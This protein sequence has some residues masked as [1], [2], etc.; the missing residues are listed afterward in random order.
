MTAI[1]TPIAGGRDSAPHTPQTPPLV[2][3]RVAKHGGTRK[4]PKANYDFPGMLDRRSWAKTEVHKH[5]AYYAC[6][7]CGEPATEMLW[8][9]RYTRCPSGTMM[10]AGAGTC[11][12]V[13]VACKERLSSRYL[14]TRKL[15][16]A[17]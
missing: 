3:P 2:D 9:E 5:T 13:C 11:Y 7:W 12:A 16:E 14:Q 6:Q 10:K 8:D 1:P 17:S 4:D 15:G